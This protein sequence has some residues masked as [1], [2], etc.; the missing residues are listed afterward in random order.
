MYPYDYYS[1]GGNYPQPYAQQYAPQQ[2]AYLRR[3]A[4]LETQLGAAK[5]AGQ[6]AG[7]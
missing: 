5:T 3:I 6:V 1:S 7:V 2:D 4:E